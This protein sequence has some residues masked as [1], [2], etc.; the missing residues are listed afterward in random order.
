MIPPRHGGYIHPARVAED[1]GLSTNAPVVHKTGVAQR[2]IGYQH[3]NS[4][5]L[6]V[7]DFSE[8]QHGNRVRLGLAT[9]GYAQN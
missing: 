2:S 1:E 4:S 3:R 5:H 8:A 7:Y 6:I 9:P